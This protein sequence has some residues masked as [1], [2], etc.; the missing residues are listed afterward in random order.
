MKRLVEEARRAIHGPTHS[1]EDVEDRL[2]DIIRV[3]TSAGG[4]RAKAVVA[5]NEQSGEL[6]SGQ[7]DCPED[8]SHWLLKF[9]GVGPDSELGSAG[10]FGRIEFAYHL[11][12]RAAGIAMA[13]CRLLRENGRSHF[14]TRRFDRAGNQRIHLQSLCA[15]QHMNFRQRATHG[16]ES[17]FLTARALGLGDETHTEIF[18]RAAFNIAAKNHD[19][20]S[21]NHA[22]LLPEQGNWQLSPAFDVTFAYN[23]QGEWTRHHL[24]GVGGKFDAITRG[25]LIEMAER[26]SVPRAK[27]AIAAVNDSVKRWPDF[28]EQAGLDES[29][30]SA[31]AKH[32]GAL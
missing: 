27:E 7:F 10:Q 32:H 16:Y 14:M 31:I 21:K 20:H 25:D 26:F 2:R 8:F 28:A 17:L 29:A 15:L 30:A 23:P 4:A 18:R 19:D 3:G 24:M 6:R 13:D 12:A 22:F 5:F 11:M 9:D 1:E